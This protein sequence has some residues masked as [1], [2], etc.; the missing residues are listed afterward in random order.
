MGSTLEVLGAV[1]ISLGFVAGSIPPFKCARN[2]EK[3]GCFQDNY[4]GKNGRVYPYELVNTRDPTNPN[5]EGYTLDWH[6]FNQSLHGLACRCAEKAKALGYTFF[7][8]QY[9]G[10]CWSGPTAKFFR[11]G[12]SAKCIGPDYKPCIH[13]S[14]SDCIGGPMTNY[15]YR[16]VD[17]KRDAK[18]DGAWTD[19]SSWTACSASCEGG[20][21][22]RHRSCTN[23]EPK[24]GGNECE[25]SSSSSQSCNTEAC[26]QICENPLE[27]AIILDA[28]TS[29]TRGNWDE[30]LEFVN[31]FSED[32]DISPTAVHFGIIRFSWTAQLI[33]GI[34]DK[35][36]WNKDIFHRRVSKI[37]YTYGGTRTDL[38]IE[39]A[40]KK[41][42]CNSCGLR[43][44]VPRAL[45]VLTD[46]KASMIAAPMSEVTQKLKENGVTIIAIGV[47]NSIDP[48][49]LSEIAT[50]EN[51]V[52]T[53]HDYR[54]LDDPINKLVKMTCPRNK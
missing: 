13:K 34:T 3:I 45:I 12:R 48:D 29:V 37:R 54:Y 15:M 26:E 23:P 17:P 4:I 5:W 50:D 38:A 27:I 31:K 32:F 35:Q 1:L 9:Y 21:R 42:L 20:K 28:S 24:N 43:E 51:H 39:M 6:R 22:T 49:E 11:D 7:G 47:G 41:L 40:E 36:Y 10:E 44:N 18:V 16:I 19:W 8:L 2:W 14:D 30:T 52:M 33:F 25:G 53:L 46:G